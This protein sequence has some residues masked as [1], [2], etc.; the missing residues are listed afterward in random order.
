MS[1]RFGALCECEGLFRY[2]CHVSRWAPDDVPADRV[3]VPLRWWTRMS[4]LWQAYNVYHEL[5]LDKEDQAELTLKS[6][7]S[8]IHL[9]KHTSN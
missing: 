8:T 3:F 2:K 7:R 9:S 6:H 5:G 1:V 4:S